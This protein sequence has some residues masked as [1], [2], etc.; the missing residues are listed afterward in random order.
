MC[1]GCLL[2]FAT[3]KESDCDTYKSL[4]GILHKDLELIVEDDQE[5]QLAFPAGKKEDAMQ[6]EKSSVQRCSCCGEPLKVRSSSHGKGKNPVIISQAPA[7]SPR[8]SYGFRNDDHRN[9][10]LPHIRYT[11]LK[12]SDTESELLDDDYG[13]N[14]DKQFKEDVKAVAVP[15]LTDPDYANEDKTPTF[16]KGNRFFGI[17][18]S[19]SA[20]NSPRWTTR[21]AKKSML[22]RTENA[23]DSIEGNMAHDGDGESILHHL[24]RQ[25]RLD[26]KSLM[27]L[28]MELDE[29]RSASAVAANNAMAMITRLQAEKAAVQMEALQYQRM[30]EEQAEYDQ[31]ALQA[32]NTLLSKREEEIKDLEAELELYREK[33]GSLQEEDATDDGTDEDYQDSKSKSC[34]I[35]TVADDSN[36]LC[37]SFREGSINGDNE[38]NHDGS[39]PLQDEK[40]ERILDKT[41][42][43]D[44][45]SINGDDEHNHNGIGSPEDDEKEGI[46]TPDK[47]P[48]GKRSL[49]SDLIN[50]DNEHNQN[51]NRSPQDEKGGRS[52]DESLVNERTLHPESING[53]DER[54]HDEAGSVEDVKGVRILDKSPESINEN[55]EQNQDGAGSS[56]DEKEGITPDR[57]PA[58]ER[59]LKSGSLD[60]DN[61]HNEPGSL[62]DEKGGK[63]PDK[64]PE[65]DKENNHDGEITPKEDNHDETESLKDE[66]GE[67]SHDKSSE[68]ERTDH[69]D[70]EKPHISSSEGAASSQPSNENVDNVEEE[71]GKRSKAI[72]TKELSNLH[73]R[74]KAL[75]ADNGFLEHVPE[76]L[77]DGSE[78]ATLLTEI[79]NNLH[80]L[81]KIL[82]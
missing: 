41:L 42:T 73:E 57:S 12:F 14:R 19:D 13:S 25:V 36:G 55:N 16:L 31:E 38:H 3:E 39:R 49:K 28:Y 43:G 81:F 9:L 78:G 51:T 45:E 58:G 10:D 18:L 7:P 8:A 50:G 70:H 68:G 37:Y 54:N 76:K 52:P 17:P 63:T 74:V 32:T 4:V 35:F 34:A 47:S 56:Q 33:Y 15:L 72:L 64:S 66:K 77:P 21:F 46:K 27:E 23:S 30:M 26:R 61:E 67:E 5:I 59:T 71:S 82:S 69:L 80:K 79:S 11:E 48:E 2:S 40:G 44:S 62:E 29:E 6:L 60:V 75:E 24:K 22:E 65:G 53:D 20:Q 1:E